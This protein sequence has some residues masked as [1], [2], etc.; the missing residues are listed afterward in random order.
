LVSAQ[1][2][3]NDGED[4][5]AHANT[6]GYGIAADANCTNSGSVSLSATGSGVQSSGG[7][8]EAVGIDAY[9]IFD[10]GTISLT[11]TGVRYL[12][13]DDESRVRQTI[14]GAAPASVSSERNR[15]SLTAA[16]S[17]SATAGS[18][19]AT[20]YIFSTHGYFFACP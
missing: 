13:T 1:V 12:L 17:G 16:V 5:S 19:K 8:A 7:W 2:D 20:S 6:G 4:S 18:S 15:T 3:V 14:A 9:D 11:D 10:S